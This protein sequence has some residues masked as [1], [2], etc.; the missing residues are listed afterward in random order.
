MTLFF[1][2]SD[3]NFADTIFV[4]TFIYLFI[5]LFYCTVAQFAMADEDDGG[6]DGGGGDDAVDLDGNLLPKIS[7]YIHFS[8]LHVR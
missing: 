6:Y 3:L 5:Y 7:I 2:Q 1:C 8:L 4:V